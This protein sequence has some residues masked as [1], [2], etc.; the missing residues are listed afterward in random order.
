MLG[1][2]DDMA[3][4]LFDDPLTSRAQVFLAGGVRLHRGDEFVSDHPA[5]AHT[6]RAAV[7]TTAATTMET[8]AIDVLPFRNGLKPTTAWYGGRC[9]TRR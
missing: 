1:N 2:D 9:P 5:T 8:S 4:A 7:T 3:L 6:T